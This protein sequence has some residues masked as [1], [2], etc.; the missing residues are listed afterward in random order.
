MKKLI[1]KNR[2]NEVLQTANFET[3]EV[4]ND[5][6]EVLKQGAWGKPEHQIEVSPEVLDE[7]GNVI[8]E[9]TFETIPAE[10][11]VEILDIT[12]EVEQ[13]RIN[14]EAL[15]YLA[16]TD[17][18]IVRESETQVVCPADIKLERAAARSRI[19]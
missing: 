1:I 10:Y 14:I 11:T 17:W 2:Q 8:Q 12:A 15:Q 13:Q 3:D 7:E 9:A 5:F 4:L 16:S 19:K 18:L 6:I